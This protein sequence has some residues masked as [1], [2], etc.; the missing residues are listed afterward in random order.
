MAIRYQIRKKDA[1]KWGRPTDL[2]A[3]TTKAAQ[4][5]GERDPPYLVYERDHRDATQSLRREIDKA[6]ILLRRRLDASP[7]E[8]TEIWQ[9]ESEPTGFF[10]A[11]RKVEP[12]A[13]EPSIGTAPLK[14]WHGEVFGRVKG[15][16]SFGIFNCRPI[17]GTTTRSQHSFAN[18]EDVHGTSAQM[19]KVFDFTVENAQ[20]LKLAHVIFNR[21]IWSSDRA[22]EGV[23]PFTGENPHTDH[24]HVDFNPQRSGAC[25]TF[26]E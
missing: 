21:K 20:R 12:A 17:A 19:K 16:V 5:V 3:A 9:V 4:R 13:A 22:S 18:G 7:I 25:K 11:V 8:N 23:R 26:D 6:E 2:K 15:L 1:E 10:V 24:V 14:Q